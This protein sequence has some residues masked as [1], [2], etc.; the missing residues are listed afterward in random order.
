MCKDLIKVCVCIREYMTVSALEPMAQCHGA[1]QS[2]RLPQGWCHW[3]QAW[4]VAHWT[5]GIDSH[6]LQSRF[7]RLLCSY[8]TER[9]MEEAE[10]G[11][12]GAKKGWGQRDGE[13]GTDY[14]LFKENSSG[15]Q[16]YEQL[17]KSK[18]VC[19]CASLLRCHMLSLQIGRGFTA[20][21]QSRDKLLDFCSFPSVSHTTSRDH[22]LCRWVMSRAVW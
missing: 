2:T 15:N 16:H 14:R 5:E 20:T 9:D 10:G 11:D 7:I 17:K 1:H 13:S 8:F 4:L 21:W 12:E 19:M 22:H 6:Y 3:H 18:P